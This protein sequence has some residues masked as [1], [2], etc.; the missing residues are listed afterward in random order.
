MAI[1]NNTNITDSFVLPVTDG[2]ISA[3]S[4]WV[5]KTYGTYNGYLGALNAPA[6][7]IYIRTHILPLDMKSVLR[8]TEPYIGVK[9]YDIHIKRLQ[10]YRERILA[11]IKYMKGKLGKLVFPVEAA[12]IRRDKRDEAIR[13]RQ[14]IEEARLRQQQI[15][16]IYVVVDRLRF[17]FPEI[18]TIMTHTI[19]QKQLSKKEAETCC[20]D[21][22]CVICLSTHKMTDACTINCGHQFGRICLA[23]WK[24]DTCPLCRTKIKEITEFVLNDISVIFDE[25]VTQEQP[26]KVV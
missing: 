4:V 9:H 22:D 2:Q 5:K 3:F 18:P 26:I 8:E 6:I 20:M 1:T 7:D 19:V 21:N 13:R 14:E 15:M 12:Q 25:K 23:K 11:K 17:S 24:N 10:L 16:A